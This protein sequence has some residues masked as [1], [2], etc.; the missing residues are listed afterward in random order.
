[1]PSLADTIPI[2][3]NREAQ[4][5]AGGDEMAEQKQT[6]RLGVHI[7]GNTCAS[8]KVHSCQVG[9]LG[10]WS[11]ASLSLVSPRDFSLVLHIRIRGTL[12]VR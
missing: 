10:G 11:Q 7:N 4:K 8:T 6:H 5:S 1:M 9:E 12:F 3:V 2:F